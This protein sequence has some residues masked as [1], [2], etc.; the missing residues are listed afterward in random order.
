MPSSKAIR[1]I[2][3]QPINASWTSFRENLYGVD[4]DEFAVNIAM[5]RLWL[6]LSVD[7]E[8]DKPE[9]LPNLDYKVAIGDSVTGPA[10]EPPDGQLRSEDSL[11]QQ[12]QEHI[13]NYQVTYTDPEKQR[14]RET[15]TELKRSLQRWSANEDE[16]VWQVEFSEVFQEGGFDIIVGNP[17][18]LRHEKIIPIKPILEQQFAAVYKSTADLYVYFYKRG[19]EL[20]RADGILTYISS[21]KFFRSKYGRKLRQFFTDKVSLR[22]LLDFGSVPVFCASVDTCIVLVENVVPGAETFLAA[23]F[24][25]KS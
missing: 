14:L 7:Y 21:N 20:L 8:E 23:T 22:K 9:P 3:E 17:P 2:P 19:T 5:L 16:F 25:N 1:L 12:I 18:Y 11:I 15:I 13:A 4:N 24:R 10:P 6:S